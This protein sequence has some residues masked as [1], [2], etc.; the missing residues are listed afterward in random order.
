MSIAW[1]T[2]SKHF[3]P[4]R[5]ARKRYYIMYLYTLY[6]MYTY[7]TGY[8]AVLYHSRSYSYLEV[9]YNIEKGY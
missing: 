8:R 9:L 6:C 1:N 5:S 7:C 2:S 4:A 3:S